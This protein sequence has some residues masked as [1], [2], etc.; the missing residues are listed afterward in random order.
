MYDFKRR[1]LINKQTILYSTYLRMP[2]KKATEKANYSK[3]SNIWD[4]LTVEHDS[5]FEETIVTLQVPTQFNH[6]KGIHV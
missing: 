2:K 6:K 1:S 3:T 5:K 4:V